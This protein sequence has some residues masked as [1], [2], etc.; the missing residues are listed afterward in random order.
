MSSQAHGVTIEL[1][2]VAEHYFIVIKAT[3]KLTH[4]D[5]LALAP[6]LDAA[7]VKVN[8]PRV[9]VLFDASEF[10]GWEI[11]A[12]WD[13]VKFAFTHGSDFDKIA[14]YGPHDWQ[15]FAA[16]LGDWFIGGQ[17]RSFKEYNQAISW[18]ID[19]G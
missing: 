10:E 19:H 3:G 13:D 16:K 5:Y 17:V 6:A 14:L 15:S 2:E 7:I 1:S 11:R 8:Q 12:A 18:L 9:N 4:Q